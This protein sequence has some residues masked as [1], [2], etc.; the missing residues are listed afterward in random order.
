MLVD[1][2]AVLPA[3]RTGSE[4][5]TPAGPH[6]G[7]VAAEAGHV[8]VTERGGGQGVVEVAHLVVLG[9]ALVD[10]DEGEPVTGGGVL[11]RQHLVVANEEV[12]RTFDAG[13]DLDPEG[14]AVRQERQDVVARV[15]V[16]LLHRPASELAFV[17][18]HGVDPAALDHPGFDGVPQ[19]LVPRNVVDHVLEGQHDRGAQDAGWPGRQRPA[20]DPFESFELG[21]TLP[22]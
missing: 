14:G 12:D 11:A 10:P 13:L 4:R 19:R 3:A 9:A 16:R 5:W 17:G 2:C 18:E 1:T 7:P 22:Q 6:L 20:A 15:V 8:E 21:V